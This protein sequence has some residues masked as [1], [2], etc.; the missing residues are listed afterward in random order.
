MKCSSAKYKSYLLFLFLLFLILN[1]GIS[2]KDPLL[3]TIPNL[4]LTRILF[5]FDASQS[6]SGTWESDQK[7]NI[8]RKILTDIVDSLQHVEKVQMA[9]RV[10]GHQSPVPPQDCSDTK[11]EVPF[12]PGNASRIR[13]KLRFITPR[14]TTPIANSLALS[15]DDFPPCDHCRNIIVL[16]TDGIEACDGDPCAVS[17]ELQKKGII[18]KPFVIGI[19][20]DPGF[21]ETFDCVGYY[22]NAREE[23]KFKQTL[24]F[25]INHVLNST[26]AQV[27]LLDEK[28]NPTE[29][30]VNMTFYDRYTGRIVYNFLHT[31]NSKGNPDTLELDPLITY[32]LKIHTIPPVEVDSV[33]VVP[34]KHSVIQ[35]KVPQGYLVVKS[36]RGKQYEGQ[37]FFV[38]KNRESGTLHTQ[39]IGQVEKYIT[40]TYEIEIPTIPRIHIRDIE[41]LQSQT[42]IIN[43]PE[44]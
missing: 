14:G 43:I 29:T 32:H 34:G 36:S 13:E 44:P 5:V 38:R 37:E 42:R 19:G 18:L 27:N 40:G 6:M 12:A 25:V 35:A 21:R 20:L 26:S 7:I 4:P 3:R 39:E 11:L 41:I 33:V 28:G 22:Y 10:Y 8:A 30:N 31:M 15:A 17:Q 24:G 2:Q 9:L 1:P 23:T 16:I